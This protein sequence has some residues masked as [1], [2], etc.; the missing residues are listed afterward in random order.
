MWYFCKNNFKLIYRSRVLFFLLILLPIFLIGLLSETFSNLLE[1]N[2]KL[3]AFSV[4]YTCEDNSFIEPMLTQF[5]EVCED[6]GIALKSL[7]KETGIQDVKDKDLD[8]YVDFKKADYTLYEDGETEEY[9]M[10]MNNILA[11]FITEY[12]Q[13]AIT[14]STGK[15]I[16]SQAVGTVDVQKIEVEPIADSNT[17]YGIVEIV[18]MM[19]CGIISMA[20]I[21]MSENKHK[22][23]KRYYI[24]T[25]S[26][27]RMYFS[28]L[29]A[30]V[31]ALCIQMGTAIAITVVFLGVNW[32]TVFY[33]S[34]GILFLE[35]V[36][37][38]S[39]SIMLYQIIRN[40]AAAL[41]IEF[42]VVF[43]GGFLGG[44][45]QTYMYSTVSE[46]MAKCS[47]GYYINRTLVEYATKGESAYTYT[48]IGILLVIIAICSVVSMILL[49][50]R[51]EA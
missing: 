42:F 22:V 31:G 18:Y 41:A 50:K 29:M 49:N 30:C 39:L 36:A 40:T 37:V 21:N 5:R 2:K 44:S 23:R 17:Y 48:C 3:D 27:P 32:G 6:N 19:W 16:A 1:V 10:I 28:K 34:A 25:L 43:I 24:S 47:P 14:M 11:S 15:E 7:D 33:K 35:A 51:R 4:G 26:S 13:Q 8:I 12:Q 45:F 9:S 38:S 20:A 46:S